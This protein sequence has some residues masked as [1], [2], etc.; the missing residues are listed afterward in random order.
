MR[1]FNEN[2]IEEGVRKI[3]EGIGDDVNRDGLKD[4][5]KRISGMYRKILDGLDHPEEEVKCNVKLFDEET[6]GKMVMIKNIPFYSF[7]EHHIIPFFGK[8][9]IAYI[10]KDN[11]IL[12]ISK[13]VRIARV[14]AKRL[15]V[16]ERLTKEIVDAISETVPNDGVAV[17]MEMEHLCMSIRGVRTSGAT[18]LTMRMTGLFKKNSEYRQEFM[19]AIK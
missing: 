13:L 9:S 17:R 10:P 12:G 1:K 15:Q 11:K 5:P 18:T 2:L 3:I 19:E 4:T 6:D 14:F 7:C 8:L 16:Q